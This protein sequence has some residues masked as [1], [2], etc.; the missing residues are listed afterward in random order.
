MSGVV[1]DTGVLV[2][3]DRNDRS[4]WADHLVRL[5]AGIVPQVPAAVVAQASRSD[6]QVQL[7]RLLRGCEIVAFDEH[8]AHRVGL[9]LGKTRSSDV[10]DGAVVDL[11]AATH[12]EIVTT[13]AADVRRLVA[14][15]GKRVVVRPR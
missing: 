12:S 13:D 1:Y 4:T 10:V 11:A 9:L 6:R 7:R 15:T 5:A 8:A 14:A 2:A 3:A